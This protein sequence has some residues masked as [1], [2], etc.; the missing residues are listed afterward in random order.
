MIKVFLHFSELE[1]RNHLP[2]EEMEIDDEDEF[3][4]FA[5]N[6]FLGKIGVRSM[7]PFVRRGKKVLLSC[8]SD[9]K[10]RLLFYNAQNF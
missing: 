5:F 6:S 7:T 4:L 2:P 3:D 1:T 10:G 9:E 8:I